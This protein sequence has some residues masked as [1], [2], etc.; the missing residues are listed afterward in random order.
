[1]P[2][3]KLVLEYDGRGFCGWQAQPNGVAVQVVVEEALGRLF[4]TPV[5]IRA[6]GRTDAGVHALGQVVTFRTELDRDPVQIQRALNGTMPNEIA[7]VDASYAPD[8]FEPRRWVRR[9]TYRYR[10]L[11]R[12]A[13]SPLRLGRCWHVRRPLDVA[14]MH[15]AAQAFVGQHDFTSFRAAG[16]TANHPVRWLE[17]IAVTAR[18]DD[19]VWLEVTGN[20]FLRHMVRI[21]AGTLAQIGLGRAPV[22]WAAEVLAAR[23]RLAAAQTAPPHGLLLVGIEYDAAPPPWIRPPAERSGSGEAAGDANVGPDGGEGDD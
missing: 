10:Y 23:D 12:E 9:K 11:T 21:M 16:C 22:G 4:H 3:Y 2:H 15:E 5:R 20:G 13:R 19:E 17:A 18:P 14:A 1:M 8:D 6:S 7:V